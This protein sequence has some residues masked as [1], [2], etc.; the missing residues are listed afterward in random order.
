MMRRMLRGP[1]RRDSQTD[2]E[3]SLIEHLEELRRRLIWV[4]VSVIVGMGVGWWLTPAVLDHMVQPVGETVF[5]AP[6]EAFH[7]HLRIAFTLALIMSIPMALYQLGAFVWP[8]LHRH[9]RKYV[10]LFIP[11]ALLLFAAGMGFAYFGMLPILF[12]FFLGFASPT[13]RPAISIGNYVSFV[14]NLVFP[15]GLVFQLPILVL[16]L[17]RLGILTPV[18]LRQHRKMALLFIFIL[19]AFLTPPDPLS[20]LLMA[21]PLLALY[22][23]SLLLSVVGYRAYTQGL[24]D[25]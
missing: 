14:T 7:T 23:M 5:L 19:A 22:E 8:A 24:D 21:G 9:E 17:S 18:F 20:Q 15:T 16:F 12:T 25:S 4:G 11:L 1:Q 10:V 6:G 3:L 13:L 2:T